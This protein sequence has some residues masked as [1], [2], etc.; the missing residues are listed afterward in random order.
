MEER[1]QSA[2]RDRLRLVLD[3]IDRAAQVSG[4]KADCVRLVAATKTVSV[5][6]IREAVSAGLRFAGESRL[7]EAL[8]KIQALREEPLQWH[9][10]GR[11]QRRKVRDIVGNFELIHS[12][13]NLDLAGE[14]DRR[15]ASGGVRQAVLLEVNVGEEAAKVGFRTEELSA[16][17]TRVGE[18]SH[19]KVR[20][21]MAIP[22]QI[23]EAERARPYFRRM[24]ELAEQLSQLRVP[25]VSM[26]EL[27]MGMSNDYVIAIEEGAT[28]VRVGTA[29]FGARRI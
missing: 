19:V 29:I 2:I 6:A 22:P 13:D 5:D 26:D 8:P 10:I 11:L 4:R 16:A 12:V 18:L 3:R 14:I 28:I 25:A 24:R 21:L 9:F 15:A 7:Q 27:S 23:D 20:G 17:L 1:A